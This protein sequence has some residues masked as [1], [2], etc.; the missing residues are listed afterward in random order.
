MQTKVFSHA[1]N[2]S[3][4]LSLPLGML[5]FLF[6]SV[7]RHCSQMCVSLFTLQL[8]DINPSPWKVVSFL[9]QIQSVISNGVNCSLPSRYYIFKI[10]HRIICLSSCVEGGGRAVGSNPPKTTT[11]KHP[12]FILIFPH[13]YV[14]FYN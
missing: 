1:S 12:H 7:L 11:M 4:T 2:I 9:C 5:L 3:I 8:T 14:I 13:N 10:H 6:Y